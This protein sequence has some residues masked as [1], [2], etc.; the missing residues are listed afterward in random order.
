MRLPYDYVLSNRSVVSS[1]A[2]ASDSSVESGNS[3]TTKLYIHIISS[4]VSDNSD[5]IESRN[6]YN[7]RHS[8]VVSHCS[9]V[10]DGSMVADTLVED[11]KT[12]RS[13]RYPITMTQ[14]VL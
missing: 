7:N 9:V 4:I 6:L 12:L 2:V 5:S 1:S 11:F 3:D 14:C 8:P 13:V 10:T